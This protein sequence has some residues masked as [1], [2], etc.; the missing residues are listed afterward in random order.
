MDVRLLYVE[1]CPNMAIARRRLTD[2]LRRRGL[3][4]NA[5]EVTL[6][7]SAAQAERLGFHGSPTILFDG[8]DPFAPEDAPVGLSCRIYR[9][10]AGVEGAPSVAQLEEALGR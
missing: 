8:R 3:D 1:D 7:A 9:T 6:V 4:P 2:A 5:L 10:E